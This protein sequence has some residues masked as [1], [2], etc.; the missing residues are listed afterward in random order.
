MT[1]LTSPDHLLLT[2]GSVIL[3]LLFVVWASLRFIII[4]IQKKKRVIQSIPYC[5]SLLLP[6]LPNDHNHTALI[7]S[8]KLMHMD[9]RVNLFHLTCTCQ[10]FR[11]VRGHYP[12][13]DIRRMCRH[14]RKELEA[15]N[16][17]Q[18]YDELTRG[19]LQFRVRDLCYTREPLRN[20]EM[21]VGFHPR[22]SIVRV[23]TYRKTPND[24]I[25]G[26]FSGHVDKFTFNHGQEIW[27]YGE[28]PPNSA[29]ILTVIEQIMTGCRAKYP[30]PH[31]LPPARE[32]LAIPVPITEESEKNEQAAL[33][34]Q[35]L[36]AAKM[37]TTPLQ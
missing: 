16:S 32:V 25:E 22:S 27:V 8:R 10:R 36:N 19:V 37:T 33:L 4:P 26:P 9:Y 5:P 17:L 23:Y 1:E 2:W 28:P 13:N 30:Q 24:P 31:Q 21:I 11:M 3:A 20:S 15:T 6:Q 18:L 14:L 12:K 34:K 7:P 35:K 29:E